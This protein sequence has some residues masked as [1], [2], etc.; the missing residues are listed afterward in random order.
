MARASLTTRRAKREAYE[1]AAKSS[2]PGGGSRFKALAASAKAGGAT[3]PEAVAAAIGRK[4]YGAK[5]F[6]QMGAKGRRGK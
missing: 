6:T 5:K 3:N 1:K 4:K 2:K